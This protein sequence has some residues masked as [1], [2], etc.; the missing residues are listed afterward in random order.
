MRESPSCSR[1]P[2]VLVHDIAMTERTRSVYAA[3]PSESL[4]IGAGVAIF[5][6]ASERVVICHHRKDHY[7]F[8]PKG[9]KNANEDVRHAAEREGFEETGYYNRLLPLP[10]RHRQTEPDEGYQANVT[11]A[12]YIQLLPLSTTSQYLLFWYAAETLPDEVERSMSRSSY[13]PPASFGQTLTLQRRI[14]MDK[15]GNYEPIK[16]ENTAVNE[17]E[18]YYESYLLSIPDA[19]AKLGPGVMADVVAR[20]WSSIQSRL[21]EE[22]DVL[23]SA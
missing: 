19:I 20:C 23:S 6:L 5:H 22:V 11:E 7:W 14:D 13:E 3:F 15:A 10:I 18:S 21:Q 17:E 4:T 16:H 8:L 1:A 12:V 2:D 9:R